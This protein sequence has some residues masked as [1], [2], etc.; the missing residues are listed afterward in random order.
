M[1]INKISPY[2]FYAKPP[3]KLV[4]LSEYKGIILELTEQDKKEIDKIKTEIAKLT[5]D[6][7][8]LEGILAKTYDNSR[9]YYLDQI[10]NIEYEIEQKRD[11][12]KKI[13]QNR[14]KIQDMIAEKTKKKS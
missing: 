11:E 6:L 2:T 3:H 14:L 8:K 12:I 9:F 13:K 1:Y 7:S 10:G 5:L 4:P